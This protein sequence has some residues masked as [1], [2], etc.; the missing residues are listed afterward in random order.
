MSSKWRKADKGQWRTARNKR[1]HAAQVWHRPHGQQTTTDRLF[2][3]DQT[4]TNDQTSKKRDPR[5]L[6]D[7]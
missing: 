6:V 4:K 1:Q 3:L 7:Q 5:F 2:G